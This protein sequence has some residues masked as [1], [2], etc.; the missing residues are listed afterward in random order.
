MKRLLFLLSISLLVACD[1]IGKEMYQVNEPVMMSESEFRSSV[2]VT[3]RGKQITNYGKICFY[4]GYLFISKPGEGIHII[5]NRNP[6]KPANVGFVELTGN[7]DIAIKNDLLYADAVMDLVWFDITNPAKPELKGR[8]EDA[9]PETFPPAYNEYGCDYSNVYDDNGQKKGVLVGWKL[10]RREKPADYYP[11]ASPSWE[12][13]YSDATSGSN[14][15]TA[16]I[17]GSMSRFA[18]YDKYMYSVLNYQMQIFDLSG[19]KPV[20]VSDDYDNYIGNVET[21]FYYKD[22]M[23]LGMPTGMSIY[24]LEDPLKPRRRST[25]THVLGCDPVVVDNDLA[26][27]TVHSGNFCGQNNDELFIVDVKD[28]DH[29]R[30]LVSYTMTNPKGLGIDS[31]KKVLFLCDDGLKIFKIGGDPQQLVSNQINH[32]EG[33]DGYDLIPYDNVVMMIADDGLYQY[34][35]SNLKAIK[36]LSVIPVKKESN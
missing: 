27:V 3:T 33:M 22:C 14:K 32:I 10:A 25:I 4:N 13:V 2:K 7:A 12:F 8:L 34:D 19:A 35:Y 30:Q 9:F 21:I 29:P 26:Y 17:N 5:D 24:S 16:G 28:V 31:E 11:T 36:R 18:L 20:K 6:S 1:D 15:S 23:F